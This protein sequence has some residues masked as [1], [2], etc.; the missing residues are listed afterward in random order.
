LPLDVGSVVCNC[1]TIAAIGKYLR[2]GM[3]L[4]EKCIT[5]D[6]GAVKEPKNVLAPI[7][8]ALADV[9]AFCGGFTAEPGKVLYGGPM[10]GIAVPDTA[11]P[12]LKNTNAILALS[13]KEAAPKKM[14]EC[15]RCGDCAR[16]CPFRLDP[17][18]IAFAYKKQDVEELERLAVDVC[19]EC[20]SCAY[21]C[22]AGR[23][24]IENHRL[25]KALVREAR[26]KRQAKEASKS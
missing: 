25:A 11:V 8:T 24:L 6:G 22:P 21:N 20:G 14:T 4:V 1:T 13:Q 17:C 15:L 23:P 26:A 10:M 2:T 9:F 12:V 19:M 3:P 18:A 7:G 16:H 5:V